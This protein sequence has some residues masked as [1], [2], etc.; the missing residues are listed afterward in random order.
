[1]NENCTT[2]DLVCSPWACL[3]WGVPAAML[4]VGL[5]QSGWRVWLWVPALALAGGAC[6]LNAGRCGRLHCYITGPAFLLAAVY[7]VLAGFHIVPLP[8]ER[9]LMAVIAIGIAARL[10]EFA[11]GRY[12]QKARAAN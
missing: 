5:Y 3:L 6:I 8:P 12:T 10:A 1:M 4:L 2:R 9:F 11:L 7:V